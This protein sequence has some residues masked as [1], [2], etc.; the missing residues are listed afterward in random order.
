VAPI[1]GACLGAGA[2]R[3]LIARHLPN[4]INESAKA[5]A[6]KVQAS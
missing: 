4:S 3:V 5:A 6:S 1:V 2:Y